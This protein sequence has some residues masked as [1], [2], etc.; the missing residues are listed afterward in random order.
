MKT[1]SNRCNVGLAVVAVA[2]MLASSPAQAQNRDPHTAEWYVDFETLNQSLGQWYLAGYRQYDRFDGGTFVWGLEGGYRGPEGG[3]ALGHAALYKDWGNHLTTYTALSGGTGSIWYPRFRF[4]HDFNFKVGKKGRLVLI[5]GYTDI[6]YRGP[7][8]DRILAAGFSLDM[9]KVLIGWRHSWNTS[10]P[11]NIPSQ[12][13]LYMLGLGTEGRSRFVFTYGRGSQ[14]YLGDILILPTEVRNPSDTFQV[15][16]RTWTS[17]SSGFYIMGQAI[18]LRNGG[19]S[20]SGGQFGVF[21]D[22]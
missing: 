7:Y 17:P 20:M 16:Y 8:R 14:A 2:L 18:N 19:Y 4:D 21:K 10:T 15:E 9:D 12:G 5:G 11:G 3:S 13:D 22:F 1:P 6:T